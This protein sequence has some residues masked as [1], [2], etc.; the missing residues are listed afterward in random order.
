MSERVKIH[1]DRPGLKDH[2][3]PCVEIQS[4]DG[5]ILQVVRK[6]RLS[7]PWILRQYRNPVKCGAMTVL[8]PENDKATYE[9]LS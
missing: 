5:T 9:V 1:V 8:Y 4:M 7:G 2:E 3:I 6:V